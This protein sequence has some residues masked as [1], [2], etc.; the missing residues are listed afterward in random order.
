MIHRPGSESPSGGRGGGGAGGAAAGGRCG[1]AGGGPGL[2]GP[3]VGVQA[4][5]A[6]VEMTPRNVDPSQIREYFHSSTFRLDVSSFSNNQD[7]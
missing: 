1:A 4:G 3:G 5:K 2:D 7:M 6:P